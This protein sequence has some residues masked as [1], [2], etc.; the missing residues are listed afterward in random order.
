[1]NKANDDS[2]Y[3]DENRQIRK[4]TA[5]AGFPTLRLVRAKIGNYELRD[6]QPGDVVEIEPEQVL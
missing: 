2:D 3:T 5:A 1:M 4:M 6:L